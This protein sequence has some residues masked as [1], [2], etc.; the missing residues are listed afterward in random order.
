MFTALVALLT[1]I[2]FSLAPALRARRV[3]LTESLKDGQTT[4]GGGARQRFR[5]A[6]VVVEMA[7]AVV[8]LVGAGLMLRSLWSL[9]QV[10]L[11][12]DPANVLTM[13]LS[14]PQASYQKPEQVVLFYDRV[15]SSVRSLPG[16]AGRRRRSLAAARF[17]DRRLRSADRRLR[18]AARHQPE[19]GLADRH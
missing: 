17:D 13:R 2:V 7:L 4:S 6:L 8:L 9:Q 10:R 1:S 14:L 15:L 18:A 11:G 12:F 16:S 3:D 5:N 19:R